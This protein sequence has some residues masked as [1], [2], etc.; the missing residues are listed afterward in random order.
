MSNGTHDK[1][2]HLQGCKHTEGEEKYLSLIGNRIKLRKGKFRLNI[3]EILLF[4]LL[5]GK[6]PLAV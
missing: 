6:S 2:L 3:R 4:S 1:N 5:K